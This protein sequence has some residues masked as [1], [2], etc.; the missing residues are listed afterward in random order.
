MMRVLIVGVGSRGGVAPYVGLGHRLQE[1]GCQVA[2]ATH[3]TFADMVREAGLEWL[4][5]SCDK[6]SHRRAP[7]AHPV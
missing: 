2:V 7:F 6:E 4:R 1:G 3:D 5:M